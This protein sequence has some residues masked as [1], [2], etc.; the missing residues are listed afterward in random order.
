M[1]YERFKEIQDEL[2]FIVSP[3]GFVTNH[4]KYEELKNE[5]KNCKN[6]KDFEKRYNDEIPKFRGL[7]GFY[8]AEVK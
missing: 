6:L 5:L 2:L 8:F 1:T 4:N 3:E 7:N